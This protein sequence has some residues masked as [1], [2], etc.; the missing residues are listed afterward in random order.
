[1][2]CVPNCKKNSLMFYGWNRA[3]TLLSASDCN[4]HTDPLCKHSNIKYITKS[5]ERPR[6]SINITKSTLYKNCTHFR[7]KQMDVFTVK[8]KVEGWRAVQ[9]LLPSVNS[10]Y[11]PNFEAWKWGQ[12]RKRI[13][14]GCEFRGTIFVTGRGNETFAVMEV[15]RL[16][17]LVL[18]AEKG[19]HS[20]A[21]RWKARKLR[22][23]M[24]CWLFERKVPHSKINSFL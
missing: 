2:A 8:S 22:W 10:R 7:E 24:G 12:R 21:Q 1:M 23:W 16:C 13:R 19:C 18:L 15:L 5:N 3:S 9:R 4:S 17:P 14:T 11:L 6:T 20:K